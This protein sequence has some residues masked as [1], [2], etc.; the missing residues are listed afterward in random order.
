MNLPVGRFGELSLHNDLHYPSSRSDT[1]A[2]LATSTS[3]S[4]DLR[5]ADG[6]RYI[7]ACLILQLLY[8]HPMIQEDEAQ[9]FRPF[10]LIAMSLQVGP[11]PGVCKGREGELQ[12]L[13]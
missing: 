9:C 7:F 13:S 3:W 6:P 10:S 11:E 8:Q 4:H 12:S 5:S 2:R 1:A